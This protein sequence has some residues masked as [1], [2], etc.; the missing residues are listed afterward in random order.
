MKS[1]L[2]P[3][4]GPWAGQLMVMPRPR[5]GDWLEDEV[6]GWRKAG[7]D[8]V[9]SLLTAAEVGELELGDEER[10]CLANQLRFVAFPIEDR[11]VPAS[12]TDFADLVTDVAGALGTGSNVAV[13]CRQGI[14]RAGLVAVGLLIRGG[15]TPEQA[16][17]HVGAARSR[18]VPET[19]EQQRW[20]EQFALSLAVSG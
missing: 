5:G 6:R 13:H 19:P 14:G 12:A 4:S 8:T 17:Q 1:D 3:V 18:T 11:D 20:I 7:I 15:M 2:Y 10:L 9:V 16:M